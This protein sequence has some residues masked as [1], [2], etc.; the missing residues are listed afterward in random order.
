M[1]L[2]KITRTSPEITAT[3]LDATRF[4]I[5]ENGYDHADAFLVEIDRS[6]AEGTF[7]IIFKPGPRFRDYADISPPRTK[8]ID[9]Q[10]NYTCNG[11]ES[12]VSVLGFW[13][14]INTRGPEF[15]GTP[16]SPFSITTNWDKNVPLNWGTMIEIS[17][18]DHDF[19]N[20]PL[21]TLSTSRDDVVRVV[22]TPRFEDNGTIPPQYLWDVQIFIQEG[23][24][25][26]EEQLDIEITASDGVNNPP[27]QLPITLNVAPANTSPPR[28]TRSSYHHKLTD[29]PKPDVPFSP[30][31]PIGADD[32]DGTNFP[33]S[34]RLDSSDVEFLSED[35]PTEIKF[36]KEILPTDP[37]HLIIVDI[38]ATIVKEGI[39]LESKSSLILELPALSSPIFTTDEE[40]TVPKVAWNVEPGVVADISVQN[41]VTNVLSPFTPTF[42][43][44]SVY[45]ARLFDK[46]EVVTTDD[47]SL[48]ITYQDIMVDAAELLLNNVVTL[49]IQADVGDENSLRTNVAMMTLYFPEKAGNH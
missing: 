48:H 13:T 27:S 23:Y 39:S 47:N 12:A 4:A 44:N 28:F 40:F 35:D 43:I 11:V 21:P 37:R 38:I 6:G 30:D 20:A 26:I 36:L 46:F 1:L 18:Q 2:F 14:D 32:P 9:A 33:I 8:G 42:K 10:L 19:V 31:E 45:P 25:L 24:Q 17:D 49:T 5:G 15:L 29:W 41:V 22:A 7:K 16:P 34:Y 3:T